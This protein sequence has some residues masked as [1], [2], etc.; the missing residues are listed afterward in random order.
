MT[1]AAKKPEAIDL[2]CFTAVPRALYLHA[3]AVAPEQQRQ[4]T[5]RISFARRWRV[6]RAVP[7]R[8]IRL[9]AYDAAAGAGGFYAKCRFPEVGRVSY[10]TDPLV[11][12]ELLSERRHLR[13]HQA[14]AVSPS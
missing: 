4:G 7:S 5:A 14:T 3:M 13:P 6:A 1:L 10:R 11:Y 8:A 9:D 2:A 12:F